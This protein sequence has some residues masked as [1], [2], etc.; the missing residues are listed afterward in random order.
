MF[1]DGVCWES[2]GRAG[3]KN[4]TNFDSLGHGCRTVEDCRAVAGCCIF[5]LPHDECM[6]RQANNWK[7]N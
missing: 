1:R 3:E 4:F 6:R 5:E 2:W 7:L